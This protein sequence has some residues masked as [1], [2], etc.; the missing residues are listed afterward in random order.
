MSLANNL[1]KGMM[2]LLNGSCWPAETDEERKARLEKL[3][4]TA[5][6]VLALITCVVEVGAVLSR[7]HSGKLA[8]MLI[9]QT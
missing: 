9:I 7:N 1:G 6:L 3:V 8:T 5:Q 2:Q 4:A